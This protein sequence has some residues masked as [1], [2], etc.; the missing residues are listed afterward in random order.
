M[1]AAV[2]L[3]AV[4]SLF[5]SAG[6]GQVSTY[7]LLLSASAD[8]SGAVPLAG[9]SVTGDSYVFTGPDTGTKQVRFWLDDPDRSGSPDKVE[10][11]APWDFAGTAA[12]DLAI[13]F[14][15]TQLSNG[16]HSITAEITLSAGGT[17]IVTAEFTVAN[18]G[19]GG[20]EDPPPPPP[21]PP[22]SDYGLALSSS[23]DR[24]GP[25]PLTGESVVDDIYVFTSPGTGTS[26][27]R[28]WLDDPGMTG[29][30]DKVETRGPWDFA[31]SASNGDANQYDTTQLDDGA[32]SI[33]AEITLSAGGTEIVTAEFLVT[34]DGPALVLDR[35]VV[36]FALLA[37]SDA[38]SETIGVSATD[39]SAAAFSASDDAPWLQVTPASGSTPADLELAVSAAG[40]AIGTYTATVT[41]SAAGYGS[42]TIAVTLSVRDTLVPDQVHLS[43][44]DEPSTTLTVVWRTWDTATP[45]TVQFRPVGSPTWQAASG[46][47]RPSGTDG[48]LHE[49]TVTGLSPSTEYEYRVQGDGSTWSTVYTAKTAPPPGPAD[50]DAIYVADTG[51][52]GREDGLATG[53]QQVV[54]EIAA[55]SPDVVLLGG[56]YAYYNTD[57]RHGTL[58]ASID[59]WFNQMQPAGSSSPMMPTYGNHEVLLSEG[60][61]F[62]APRF[63][64]PTGFDGR[65]FYSFDVGDVHFVSLLAVTE[66][67]GL[68]SS[69][70]A[71]IE[72][73]IQAA[74]AAGQ[75]WIVPFFHV[76]PFSDGTS[77]PSNLGLRGQLGPLF[78]RLGV[79]IAI[80][81]HDQSYE[82]TFPLVDV[83]AEN[84]PTSTGKRC[85]TMDDG[86]TWVKVSPGGKLSNKNG[87]FSGWRTE[88]PPEWTAFRDNTMHHFSRLVVSAE[89]TMRLDTYG[90]VGDGSPPVIVDT[91][92]YRESCPA[93]LVLEEDEL[94]FGAVAGESAAD[95]TVSL[96]AADGSAASFAVDVDAPW[97]EVTP[98]AG[99]TPT[100]LTVSVDAT[101]LAG[102]LYSG[103]VRTSADGYVSDEM[104]VTLFVRDL[105][106][107]ASP[108]RSSPIALEGASVGGNVYVFTTPDP[109]VDRVRFW[110]D[111]PS[112]S[113]TPRKVEGN[114]PFDFAGTATNGTAHPFDTDNI[115]NG[116]HSITAALDL[117]DGTTQV[118]TRSFVVSNP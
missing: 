92:E 23:P 63:A 28:F 33:T 4:F 118:V 22:P 88:P 113:G 78:E 44:V 1:G 46:A 25:V 13:A 8:R 84:T 94:Q 85:Y 64:T 73:D 112:M 59:A 91:F 38:A 19:G 56:D 115:S 50:F 65:R 110:L 87:D 53:T 51:L 10:R 69:A 17:E 74:Q 29:T 54:D 35:T 15:T 97:L 60:F 16:A 116:T 12:N 106:V 39:G 62:W 82:R 93:E 81:S 76:S 96:S 9:A 70:L 104:R 34:N 52:V 18:D 83:P 48:T 36:S 21:P 99:S 108:D 98:T 89:G 77:H 75:R 27:V 49:V 95:Q 31:G 71:W 102:G 32:H 42:A 103:V 68:S 109:G 111:N 105:V 80:A 86:V 2:V 114:G 45:S 3:L 90:V 43:W 55:L 26:R 41:V 37:G 5:P 40:L 100:E 57:K 20:G 6:G 24:S 101:G 14:D 72:D 79:K 66:T 58:D 11:T 107:S 7:D 47:L 61:E 117:V 67:N 30:A